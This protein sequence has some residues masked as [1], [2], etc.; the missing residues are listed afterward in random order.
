M[1]IRSPLDNFP[2]ILFFVDSNFSILNLSPEFCPQ[3]AQLNFGDEKLFA[4]AVTREGVLIVY[5]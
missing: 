1:D 3:P 2:G 5:D 4:A